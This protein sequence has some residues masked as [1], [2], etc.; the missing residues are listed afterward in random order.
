MTILSLQALRAIFEELQFE[1][2]QVR[3][4]T[5]AGDRE[6]A[7]VDLREKLL[8]ASQ[9]AHSSHA[10]VLEKIDRLEKEL[11]QLKDMEAQKA[12]YKMEPLPPDLVVYVL[13]PEMA[14]GEPI[15]RI[16][17]TCYH[18][19]KISPLQGDE[20]TNGIQHLTCYEC[21]TKLATGHFVAPPVRSSR[22]D[23]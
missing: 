12:R 16:C 17:S 18:R 11:A 14:N 3:N 21:S 8:N 4:T 22:G 7:F 9:A 5:K 23:W 6:R 1:V 2:V 15:H 13:K 10:G 20:R 19:G